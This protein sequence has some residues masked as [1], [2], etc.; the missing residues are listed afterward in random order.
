MGKS[1]ELLSADA[2][3][4]TPDAWRDA[5]RAPLT[6]AEI[7]AYLVGAAI[8]APSVHNTQPWWFAADGGGI[9]LY[10]DAARQLSV[11]DPSGREMMISCG[12]ALFTAKLALRSLGFVVETR[13]LP[14][15]TN[16]LLI[17]RLRWRRRAAPAGFELRL[18]SQVTRRRTHRGGFEPLPLMPGLL[19]ALRQGAER[20]GAAL[21]VAADVASTAALAAVVE[22]AERVQ[23]S[24][25]GYARE[26]AAWAPPPGSLRPDGVSPSSYPARP[27]RT[28]PDFPGRDFARGHGW[29]LPASSPAG[30]ALYT[31][32]VCLLTTP[33]DTPADWV[34]A[35]HALQRILLTSASYGA[36]A[37]LYSQPVEVGWLREMIRVQ[38][39]DGSYP[40]LVLRLGTVIQN[41][42][43][44]RRPPGSVL[45]T[46]AGRSLPSPGSSQ[47]SGDG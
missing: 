24:D 23:R 32:V 22:M 44:V 25:S 18:F 10:A 16:P 29:G 43:S 31:G 27:D 3:V 8:W 17:A 35:G 26:L 4:L 7:T 46:S 47:S 42:V 40:Q 28:S 11:A 13:V 33:E 14:E 12:A 21:R 2:S 36:A 1:A 15:G 37:A 9:A 19:S 30:A 38:L 34:H 41:A 45:L 5:G 20:D 39:G 6:A